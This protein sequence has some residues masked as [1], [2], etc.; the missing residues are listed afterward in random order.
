MDSGNFSVTS[1]PDQ[2]LLT[3]SGDAL[4]PV[5]IHATSDSISSVSMNDMSNWHNGIYLIYILSK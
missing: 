3:L 1:K 2:N 4:K 5:V